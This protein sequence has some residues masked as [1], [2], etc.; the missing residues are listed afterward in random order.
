MLYREKGIQ[1]VKRAAVTRTAS[2]FRVTLEKKAVK[3]KLNVCL[4]VLFVMA[5]W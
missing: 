3:Q 2:L 5:E 4:P 1:P